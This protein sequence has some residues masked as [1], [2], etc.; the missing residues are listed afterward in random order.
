MAQAAH[1]HHGTGTKQ[2]HG[3]MPEL[4]GLNPQNRT[5]W[6][7]VAHGIKIKYLKSKF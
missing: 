1:E 7:W 5:G 6:K 2:T 3:R 4:A